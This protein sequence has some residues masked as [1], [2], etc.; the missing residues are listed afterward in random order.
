MVSSSIVVVFV[1]F[2]AF[3]GNNKSP[4]KR[5]YFDCGRESLYSRTQ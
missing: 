4:E 5:D 3:I 2:T 1:E